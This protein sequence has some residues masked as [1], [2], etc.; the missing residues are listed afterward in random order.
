MLIL[1]PSVTGALPDWW[2][3]GI[4]TPKI[5]LGLG[6]SRAAHSSLG[7]EVKLDDAVEDSRQ[8]RAADD[9]KREMKQNKIEGVK[10]V[11]QDPS[12]AV[13]VTL[14]SAD[15][16]AER[17]PGDGIRGRGSFPT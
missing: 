16:C 9:L 8:R 17:L 1:L 3:D 11:T 4:P 10:S 15:G 6:R 14:P 12:G 2:T 5:Q 13:L 7:P